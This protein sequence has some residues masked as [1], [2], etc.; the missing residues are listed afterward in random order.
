MDNHFFSEWSYWQQA[1]I[2]YITSLLRYLLIAGGA[3]LFFYV[4]GRQRWLRFRIQKAFPSNAK[5]RMEILWSL[6]TFVIFGCMAVLTAWMSKQGW[7][8]LYTDLTEYG[9]TW[10][11]VSVPL[12]LVL[13]DTWFYWTH[14]FMH[15]KVIFP[16][17]HKVHHLSTNPSPWASFSFHP[18]EAVIEAGIIP[19]VAVVIPAHPIAILIF[20]FLMTIMNVMGHLGYELFPKKFVRHGLFKWSNTSTHHNMHHRLVKC[21]FGLYYNFWDRIMGTNHADY[22]KHFEEVVDRREK[23]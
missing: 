13:H 14:R 17:V 12:M 9:C 15:W 19:L 10:F 11:W 16:Y 21:N 2:V 6:S 18:A 1:V 7:T 20:L 8:L 3:F 23:S 4:L 22:E 5:I